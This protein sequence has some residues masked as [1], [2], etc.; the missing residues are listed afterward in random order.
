MSITMMRLYIFIALLSCNS[1]A[2]AQTIDTTNE[3]EQAA[4]RLKS[5]AVETDWN[6][7]I[8]IS[9]S[10]DHCKKQLSLV[11]KREK[12]AFLELSK[13]FENTNINQTVLIKQFH[14]CDLGIK[15][16]EQAISC[17]ERLNTRV[18]DAINGDELTIKTTSEK[19]QNE[20]NITIQETLKAFEQIDKSFLKD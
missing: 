11:W 4:V 9:S 10:E 5:S 7:C 13:H 18:N 19:R 1:I 6:S 16:Y 12:A 8:A 14:A 17:W 3:L 2:R 20:S 15:G